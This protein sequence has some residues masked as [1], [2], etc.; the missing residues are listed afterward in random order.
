MKEITADPKAFF[1]DGGWSFLD[2]DSPESDVSVSD[3]ESEE[4]APPGV[5]CLDD[6]FATLTLH[7]KR[8]LCLC[9]CM[10]ICLCLCLCLYLLFFLF[11]SDDDDGYETPSSVADSDE[12][13]VASLS[14]DEE[15]MDWDEL[16]EQAK[17][18]LA[19]H[20]SFCQAASIW[21]WFWFWFWFWLCVCVLRNML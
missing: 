5:S 9:M 8:N 12:D 15:G 20:N 10:C 16:E 7:L 18:G 21:F 17:E 6:C 13:S 1:E 4:F 14:E 3:D 2:K 11:Q 19:N